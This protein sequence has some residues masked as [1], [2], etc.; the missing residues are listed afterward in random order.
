[1]PVP[2]LGCIL[3][4]CSGVVLLLDAIGSSLAKFVY[5][6]HACVECVSDVQNRHHVVA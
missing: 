6:L 2:R 3:A 5:F 1:M 4:G